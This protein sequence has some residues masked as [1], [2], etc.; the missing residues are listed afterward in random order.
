MTFRNSPVF[1][2]SMV[3]GLTFSASTRTACA[4]ETMTPAGKYVL[5]TLTFA[6]AIGDPSLKPRDLVVQIPL[7]DGKLVPVPHGGAPTEGVGY[8][9]PGSGVGRI[10]K[11]ELEIQPSSVKGPLAIQNWGTSYGGT[12]RGTSLTFT[13]QL[14][15]QRTGDALSGSYAGEIEQGAI[16]NGP[17]GQPKKAVTGKVSGTLI[18]E[19]TLARTNRLSAG[20][21]Y[22]SYFGTGD[23]AM[24]AGKQSLIDDLSRARFVWR[25]EEWLPCGSG[26]TSRS[27]VVPT[28][29]LNGL[30]GMPIIQDGVIYISYF[31]PS[32]EELHSAY[33]AWLASNRGKSDPFHFWLTET[34]G[35]LGADDVLA[36]IDAATGKT[37]WRVIRRGQGTNWQGHKGGP[38]NLTPVVAE[39][40]VFFAGSASMVYAVE[41]R[42]GKLLWEYEPDGAAAIRRSKPM[43]VIGRRELGSPLMVADGVVVSLR[44]GGQHN[45]VGLDAQ[46]GK[47]L[48]ESPLG[49][50]VRWCHDSKEYLLMTGQGKLVCIEPRTGK[51]MWEVPAGGQ[52][53]AVAGDR[54]VVEGV[55][56]EQ[57]RPVLCYHISATGAKQLWQIPVGGYDGQRPLSISQGRVYLTPAGKLLAVDLATGKLVGEIGAK[58]GNCMGGWAA[59]SKF[60]YTDDGKHGNPGHHWFDIAQ[61]QPK[62]L[63]SGQVNVPLTT[64]YEAQITPLIVDG[65]LFIRGKDGIYCFDLRATP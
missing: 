21:D 31:V 1:L 6:D 42:T 29:S 53:V 54:A 24:P 30:L 46:T 19:A 51:T 49:C 14:N 44:G 50:P 33:P 62:L 25:S 11:A 61:P 37:L 2:A 16:D 57:G 18:E 41:A 12:F 36:A 10:L 13:G 23:F 26:N 5:L 47:K 7:R 40:K 65:R 48:W 52:F 8:V 43:Y 22:P 35:R 3:A 9:I 28:C 32:G 58:G 27:P 20:T 59:G 64:A 39:G 4:A 55:G 38:N 56:S 63:W 34:A 15:L 17:R 60:F 45:V